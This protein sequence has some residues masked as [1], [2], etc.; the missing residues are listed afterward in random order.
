MGAKLDA[1]GQL[2]GLTYGGLVRMEFASLLKKATEDKDYILIADSH[3]DASAIR[4]TFSAPAIAAMAQAGVKHLAI[5]FSSDFQHIFDGYAAGSISDKQLAGV[6]SSYSNPHLADEDIKAMRA[7][8]PEALREAKEL[9]IKIH[10]VDV[11]RSDSR[12]SVKGEDAEL[13]AIKAHIREHHDED[14]YLAE[15]EASR[16]GIT[17]RYVEYAKAKL[18]ARYTHDKDIAE[19]LKPLAKDGKVVVMYGGNHFS[20]DMDINEYLG[21]D[22][23]AVILAHG[24]ADKD[25]T[26]FFGQY[27]KPEY[28]FY[29][30]LDE[31]HPYPVAGKLEH[32]DAM[33]TACK[34]A[35]D[36]LKSQRGNMLLACVVSDEDFTNF[37]QQQATPAAGAAPNSGRGKAF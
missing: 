37:A 31:Q 16:P 23:S 18:E 1:N 36:M 11:S 21:V 9:G 30:K 35:V 13:N 12:F 27:E 19:Y 29:D 24:S 32:D 26:G 15:Q 3:S 2:A 6:F 10:C 4:N 14:A 8:L 34:Q 33:S 17:E 25:T 7:R 28:V 22:R 20:K 5:E